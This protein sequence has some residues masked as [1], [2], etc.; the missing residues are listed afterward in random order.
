MQRVAELVERQRLDV[1]F[2]IGPVLPPVRPREDAELRGR[3]CQRPAPPHGIVQPHARPAKQGM[4]SLVQ[5]P[6]ARHAKDRPLLQM[7]L[8]VA[9]HALSVNHGGDARRLQ[10]VSRA[11]A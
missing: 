4:I 11:N 2:Q 6:R 10:P 1:E 8:Q 5:C 7:V 3:H 9:A